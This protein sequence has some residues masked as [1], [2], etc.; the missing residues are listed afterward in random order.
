VL[1]P[2][3]LYLLEVKALALISLFRLQEAHVILPAIQALKEH[4][5]VEEQPTFITDDPEALYEQALTIDP[6][7][8][9]SR[10]DNFNTLKMP[11][12]GY[13]LLRKITLTDRSTAL[14]GFLMLVGLA[15]A[16]TYFFRDGATYRS[17]SPL[18]FMLL[19]RGMAKENALNAATN[20]PVFF[21]GSFRT[22]L[23][24]YD[25]SRTLKGI[26]YY[27]ITFAAFAVWHTQKSWIALVVAFISATLFTLLDESFAPGTGIK[28]V[29]YKT[30]RRKKAPDAPIQ[31]AMA[32]YESLYGLAVCPG[33]RRF[34]QA[35][36]KT[37]LLKYGFRS[38]AIFPILFL[39][40]WIFADVP[41]RFLLYCEMIPVILL[42]FIYTLQPALGL[43]VFF[44]AAAREFVPSA[45]ARRSVKIMVVWALLFAVIA[46]HFVLQNYYMLIALV[47]IIPLLVLYALLRKQIPENGDPEKKERLIAYLNARLS[48]EDNRQ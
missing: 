26:A 46:A 42:L 4:G 19:W 2:N 40:V 47:V 28:T 45:H 18:V 36:L 39:L 31:F 20:L 37:D 48:I 5:I 33:L 23:Q 7:K 14:I 12:A 3:D 11:H 34:T 8:T 22:M 16:A 24:K 6:F 27:V 29:Q 1:K 38:I 9:K 17:F 30:T 43:K 21:T 10:L 41:Y 32:P 13:R 35:L 25:R 15:V 44:P